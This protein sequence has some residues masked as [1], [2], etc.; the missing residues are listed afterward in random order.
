[1]ARIEGALADA[2]LADGARVRVTVDRRDDVTPGA[3]FAHWE[4]RGVPFRIEI[5]PR[6][7]AADQAVLVRRLDR[8]KDNVALDALANELPGRLERY[9]DELFHR[10]VAFR[11]ANT[12]RVDSYDEFKTTLEEQ[13]GFLLGHW[14]GDDAC[15]RQIN[16]ETGATIRI[17]PMD[18]EQEEGRCLI[19]GG[20]STQR[21][22]FAR[23][24]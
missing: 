12:H 14:C 11:D 6:D 4:L 23:A 13:G 10:A 22:V 1:V 24:Y 8:V 21:V 16:E 19:D 3:K 9:Q 2:R 15:E 20:R 7:V 5:G 18:G 17:V